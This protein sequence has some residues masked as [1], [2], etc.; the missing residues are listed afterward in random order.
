[1]MEYNSTLPEGVEITFSYKAMNSRL[2]S[3]AEEAVKAN[4][5]TRRW[6]RIE[7]FTKLIENNYSIN[8]YD[9]ISFIVDNPELVI[10][11]LSKWIKEQP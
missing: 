6:N 8:S 7:E 3:T 4:I 10:D 11:F 1:M 5:A 2:Y 9:H